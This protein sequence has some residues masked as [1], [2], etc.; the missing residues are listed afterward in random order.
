MKKKRATSS[1][2]E[3]RETKRP[4]SIVAQSM[5]KAARRNLVTPPP[6]AAASS[7][8]AIKNKDKASDPLKVPPGVRVVRNDETLLW[9]DVRN[10]VGA[11]STSKKLVVPQ[12]GVNDFLRSFLFPL[13]SEEYFLEHV[14]HKRA[15]AITGFGRGRVDAL[16]D[17]YM[18]GGDV[19][20]LIAETASDDGVSVWIP[21]PEEGAIESFKVTDPQLSETLFANAG[22]SLYMRAPKIS[23][24][25]LTKAAFRSLRMPFCAYQSDGASR[26]EV[27]VFLASKNSKRTPTHTDFQE[28]FTMQLRGKKTWRV[29]LGDVLNP[30]RAKSPHFANT[31][32]NVV[33]T[34][35]LASQACGGSSLIDPPADDVSKWAE[36]ELDEGDVLYHPPGIWHNVKTTGVS[37]DEEICLSINISLV[38]PTWA[39]VISQAVRQ[40]LWMS[41]VLRRPVSLYD[42]TEVID[43]ELPGLMETAIKELIKNS[44]LIPPEVVSKMDEPFMVT[45]EHGNEQIEEDEGEDDDDDATISIEFSTTISDQAMTWTKSTTFEFNPLALL[46]FDSDANG[47][48]DNADEDGD[49]NGSNEEDSVFTAIVH[50]NI[51]SSDLESLARFE[52]SNLPKE[53]KPVLVRLR[54]DPKGAQMTGEM[55]EQQAK[56][57]WQALADI[58]VRCGWFVVAPDAKTSVKDKDKAK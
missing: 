9:L 39:D 54:D 29:H 46:L 26:G 42:T 11:A 13:A 53:L 30:L 12:L 40:Y 38:T 49:E 35:L 52:L 22:A 18:C 19:A 24:D 14:F 47:T 32:M 5:A 23:C 45:T 8:S 37:V 4:A 17:E 50:I 15:M 20:R 10:W 43:R 41:P 7:P 33:E 57:Y 2:V 34:Q 27:E 3:E 51:G 1:D 44:V 56:D 36:V 48:D 16:V 6:P 58:L 55:L 25:V 31:P 21:H 28:N